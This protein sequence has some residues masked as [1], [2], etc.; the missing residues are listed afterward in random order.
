MLKGFRKKIVILDRDGVINLDSDAFIKSPDKWIVILG[1]LEAIAQ[2]NQAGYRMAIASNQ[3]SIGHGLFA[4]N[5]LNAIHLNMH[6]MLAIIG[7]YVDAAFFA[8]TRRRINASAANQN[9]AC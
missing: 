2:L 3:S 9:L 6:R 8:R 1:N 7:G 5:A 4:M